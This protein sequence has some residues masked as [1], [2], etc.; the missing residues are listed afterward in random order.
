M[1]IYGLLVVMQL[2]PEIQLE[3]TLVAVVVQQLMPVEILV[4]IPMSLVVLHL[5]MKQG[6]NMEQ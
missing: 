3:K 4:I 6:V 2:A 5:P 1:M